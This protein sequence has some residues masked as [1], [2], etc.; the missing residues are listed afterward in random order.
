[1]ASAGVS[2]DAPRIVLPV[3]R[4]RSWQHEVLYARQ[5][6]YRRFCVV[7]HRRSGK[8]VLGLALATI[9]MVERPGVYFYLAPHYTHGRKIL[10]DGRDHEG[11][12]FLDH[13]PADLIRSRNETEMQI[14]FKNGSLFQVV[15]ADQPD[16]LRGVNPFGVVFDEY[17]VMETSNPWD[18]IRP[19]LAENG[20]WAAFF[21]TPNGRNHGY[22]LYQQARANPE[23]FVTLKTVEDTR[24]DARGRDGQPLPGE[25]GRLIIPMAQVAE[26]VRAGMP[27]ALAEQEFKCSWLAATPGAFYAAEL[28]RAERAG[29]IKTVPWEPRW[30]VVTAWDLGIDD[31]TAIVFAQAVGREVRVIDYHEAQG[32]S[33]A[34]YARVLL[35]EKP[36]R[37]S[38]HLLPHDAGARELG[39]GKSCGEM[40]TALNIRPIRILSK[41]P[42][43]DGIN[44]VRLLLPRVYFDRDR[45]KLLLRALEHYA[46]DW[47]EGK[48]TFALRPRHDWASHASDAFRYLAQGIPGV[49]APVPERPVR[50]PMP[51]YNFTAPA[52]RV[53]GPG[54]GSEWL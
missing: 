5:Q 18:L 15:G 30:P 37:Y 43:M 40:L 9:G 27:P 51:G 33:L 8:T 21:F 34:D 39:T 50:V 6:G 42:V 38:Q 25:D 49:A 29:Q 13:F 24:R 2:A 32:K 19:I 22:D 7:C 35:S 31:A 47:D 11:R 45:C 53:A 44:A 46:A 4:A 36:Y 28:E 20:G 26:E 14:A 1:M 48:K 23:W 3:L 54:P 10:W 17:A 41:L 12:S 16:R 52:R